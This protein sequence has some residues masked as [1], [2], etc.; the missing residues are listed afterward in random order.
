MY[1]SMLANQMII[2]KL[3]LQ[4]GKAHSLCECYI[5]ADHRKCT[6]HNIDP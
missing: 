3:T 2:D 4:Q 6:P 5:A 1:I